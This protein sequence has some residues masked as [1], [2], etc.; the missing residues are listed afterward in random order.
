MADGRERPYMQFNFLVNLGD[1]VTDS[2]DA[3]FQEISAI[4]MEVA[5][6][7]YR[8]GNSPFNHVLKLTGLTKAADI[9]LKRGIIGTTTLFEWL[10]NLSDGSQGTDAIKQVTIQ[11]QNEA[12]NGIVLTWQ[13]FNARIIK[14]SYGALNAKGTDV[15]MEE[16]TLSYESLKVTKGN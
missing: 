6:S 1:G 11:L 7:E 13:L 10:Q 15:A 5:A 8:R 14:L 4:S 3:G 12:R 9:T 16:M 2:Y